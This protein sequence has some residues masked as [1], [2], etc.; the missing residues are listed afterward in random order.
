M[1]CWICVREVERT[2]YE[3]IRWRD[4]HVRTYYHYIFH[5]ESNYCPNKMPRVSFDIIRSRF[6]MLLLLNKSVWCSAW[7]KRMSA[8]VFIQ[9]TQHTPFLIMTLDYI[10]HTHTGGG[11]AQK[12][13][14]R[15]QC[16]QPFCL[17]NSPTG[18]MTGCPL[19]L[20]GLN[21]IIY[22]V[23]ERENFHF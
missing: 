21:Y 15:Y 16:A 13:T 19:P 4:T 22:V 1:R 14:F 17:R 12:R 20:E 6:F 11:R 23:Y 5:I 9:H 3:A 10:T 7:V 2:P 8:D 18:Q